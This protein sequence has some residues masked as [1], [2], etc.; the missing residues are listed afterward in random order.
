MGNQP[1]ID[2]VDQIKP[3]SSSNIIRLLFFG[4]TLF[5]LVL[6]IALENPTS[7][8]PRVVIS[9]LVLIFA[10]MFQVV[11]SAVYLITKLSD[12]GS[13]IRHPLLLSQLISLSCIFLV[14]LQS[15]NQ[16]G[17]T[18]VLL[19]VIMV[20]IVYFYVIRRF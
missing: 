14:G 18:D 2:E 4:I 1:I 3:S 16:L 20:C 13:K 19:T 6:L 15:L 5:L 11:W 12:K 8:G 9:A 10:L 17:I 7:G